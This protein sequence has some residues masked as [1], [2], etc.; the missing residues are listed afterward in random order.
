MSILECGA[1]FR[2]IVNCGDAVSEFKKRNKG[3]GKNYFREEAAGAF[4]ERKAAARKLGEETS[5]RLLGP[6]FLMLGVVLMIIVVPA[7]LTIQIKKK[8]RGRYV[9]KIYR[10][11]ERTGADVCGRNAG[12]NRAVSRGDDIDIGR[13]LH[14]YIECKRGGKSLKNK[15]YTR[16]TQEHGQL[17]LSKKGK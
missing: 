6:M 10:E 5:T 12:R 13:N 17:K 4:E 11:H 3:T 8:G 14:L 16:Y 2:S 15:L 9:E 1:G 7:F